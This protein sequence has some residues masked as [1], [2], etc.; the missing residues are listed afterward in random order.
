MTE[1]ASTPAKS[2]SGPIASTVAL[3]FAMAASGLALVGFIFGHMAGHM[4]MFVGRDDYNKYAAFLQGLG[5]LLWIMRFGLLGMLAVHVASA[6]LLTKRNREARPQGY[7]ALQSQRTTPAA[8]LMMEGGAVILLFVI[9]HVLHFTVGAVH[10]EYYHLL[11]DQGRHDVYTNFVRSFQN[12]AI[13]GIYAVAIL[14]LAAHMSHAATSMFKTLGIAVGRFRRP[15]ELVG[16]ALAVIVFVGF[17]LPPLGCFF[18]AIPDVFD[19]KP[20]AADAHATEASEAK[21]TKSK[22]DDAAAKHE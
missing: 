5:E 17:L 20:G 11:D 7:R 9:Y 13:L 4:K 19:A 21:N 10:P 3:K 6:I 15:F 12:P 14:A 16:P 22:S 1:K 2:A 18:G 8:K